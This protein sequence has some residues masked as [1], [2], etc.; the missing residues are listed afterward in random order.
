MLRHGREPGVN[1]GGPRS[2]VAAQPRVAEPRHHWPPF[3]GDRE[4]GNL[5][6]TPNPGD[7]L[8]HLS[9]H[10]SHFPKGGFQGLGGTP[11]PSAGRKPCTLMGFWICHQE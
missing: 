4:D 8:L 7:I 10:P 2:V 3:L 1:P 5:G 6:D 9:C 11:K